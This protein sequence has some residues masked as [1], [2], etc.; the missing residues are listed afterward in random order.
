M[1]EVRSAAGKLVL[2]LILLLLA[3]VAIRHPEASADAVSAGWDA[4]TGIAD[5]IGR[6]LGSL[7][8]STGTTDPGA[9]P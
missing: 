2:A 1:H 9:T 8:T 4:L 5:G 3:V 6:L 7:T